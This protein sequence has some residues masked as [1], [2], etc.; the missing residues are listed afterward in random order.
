MVAGKDEERRE[1]PLPTLGG[2]MKTAVRG[3]IALFSGAS[4]LGRGSASWARSA[5]AASIAEVIVTGSRV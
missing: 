1:V 4:L 5:P 3:A 2:F